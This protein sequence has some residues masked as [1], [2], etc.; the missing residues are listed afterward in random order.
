MRLVEVAPDGVND[1]EKE[2]KPK[3]HQDHNHDDLLTVYIPIIVL[4]MLN[5]VYV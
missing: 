2:S 3:N 5:M 1:E 4:C